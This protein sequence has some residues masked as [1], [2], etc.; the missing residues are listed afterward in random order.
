MA[1]FMR[2]VIKTMC[3]VAATILVVGGWVIWL[4]LSFMS[5]A[6]VVYPP[7]IAMFIPLWAFPGGLFLALIIV[8]WFGWWDELSKPNV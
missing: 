3:L 1:S 2:F 7:A 5:K 6:A 8:C 4:P